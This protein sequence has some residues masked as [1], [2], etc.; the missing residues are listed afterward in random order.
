[1]M[2]STRSLIVAGAPLRA[3]HIRRI[4]STTCGRRERAISSRACGGLNSSTRRPVASATP[5]RATCCTYVSDSG[6]LRTGAAPWSV[7]PV[8]A[9]TATAAMSASWIG[10]V[11]ACG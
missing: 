6:P 10:A 3:A 1:M 9:V 11:S 2:L 8:S 4:V 5:I 7:I